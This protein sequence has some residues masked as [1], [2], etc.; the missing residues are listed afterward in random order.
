MR[1]P[2][3]HDRLDATGVEVGQEFRVGH[4][5]RGATLLRR[6]EQVEQCDQK[7]GYDRPEREIAVVRIYRLSRQRRD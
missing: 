6:L 7:N 4:I 3:I 5:A 1:S 2:E